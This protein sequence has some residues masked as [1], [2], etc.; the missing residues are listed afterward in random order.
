METVLTADQAGFLLALGQ[1]A[2]A[3]AGFAGVIGAF[4]RFSTDA[5]VTAFR[6]R[7]MVM[8]SLA[9]LLIALAPFAAAALNASPA[10]AWRA[11]SAFAALLAAGLFVALLLQVLPLF[12][13][14]LLRTQPLNI[15]WYGLAACMIVSLAALAAGLLPAARAWSV[16]SLGVIFLILLCAYNFLMIILSVR[17]GAAD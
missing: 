7:G 12:R 2:V 4:S 11:V 16:Y 15:V 5:R 9:A 14:K 1:I 10:G 3:F 8:L 13:E 17:P 6:V